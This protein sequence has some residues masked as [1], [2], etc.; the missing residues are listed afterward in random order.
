[1]CT[2]ESA[3]TVFYDLL[4]AFPFFFL[5]VCMHAQ[6][7]TEVHRFPRLFMPVQKKTELTMHV[8]V[9]GSEDKSKGQKYITLHIQ[10]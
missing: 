10:Q 1:M 3:N 6:G 8:T 7:D 4:I 9:Y 5:C 2:S